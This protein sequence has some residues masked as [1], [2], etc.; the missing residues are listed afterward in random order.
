MATT[1]HD[2][3]FAEVLFEVKNLS[4]Q[5]GDEGK[6]NLILRDVN[7]QVRNIIRPGMHQGQVVALLG[8]SGIGKT[9][10]FL[11]MSGLEK[12]TSGEVLV[13]NGTLHPVK[14]GQVGVVFQNYPIEPSLVVMDTLI[15]AGMQ[16]GL[17]KAEARDKGRS[18]LDQFGL[19]GRE[20]FYPRQLSGGQRQ[21]VAII[22]QLM[23]S[24]RI[25]L[26]DEPFSGLDYAAKE[27]ACELINQVAI[28]HEENTIII[29][30]H[31][32]D[33]GLQ[34]ADSVWL[35]GRERDEQGKMIP[36][37]R[38]MEVLDLIQW[39]IAWRPG[40]QFTPEFADL[41][42]QVKRKFVDPQGWYVS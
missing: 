31:D 42:Q 14:P 39:G 21:R 40:V 9:Q 1:I 24:E 26:M 19:T 30:T 25:I 17:K 12:P 8:P 22:E 13:G 6:K 38:V 37:A 11:R 29:V 15:R 28:Q 7:I 16:A 41:V 33:T 3:T 27:S 10:L 35:M 34:I 23:C 36:G 18:L 20:Q 5:L 2:H 4:L 32:I